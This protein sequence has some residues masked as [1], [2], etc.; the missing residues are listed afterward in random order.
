MNLDERFSN[1]LHASARGWRHALERRLRV[2]GLSHAGW[3]AVAAAAAMA[4]PPSQTELAQMLRVEGATMVT[5]I[6]RLVA[7]GLVERMPSPTDRRVNL[8]VVTERGQ[9][10]AERVRQASQALRQQLVQRIG[11]ERIALAAGVLEELQQILE[12]AP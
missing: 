12:E 4:R 6:D 9:A 11:G 5:T 7:A 2:T 1:A 3:S 8:V 10:L